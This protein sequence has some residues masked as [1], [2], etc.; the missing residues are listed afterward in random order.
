MTEKELEEDASVEVQLH[1]V[2]CVT[3]NGA[4]FRLERAVEGMRQL[5]LKGKHIIKLMVKRDILMAADKQIVTT[6]IDRGVF[7]NAVLIATERART[8]VYD[9]PKKWPTVHRA[10]FVKE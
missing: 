5:S 8:G 2:R 6:T 3:S 4:P 9:K 10:L 1:T 7:I